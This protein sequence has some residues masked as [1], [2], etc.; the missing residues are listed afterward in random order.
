MNLAT[1]SQNELLQLC[2]FYRAT[3]E[4]ASIIDFEI[5]QGF[6]FYKQLL[7][8]KYR[9]IQMMRQNPHL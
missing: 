4:S 9:R 1:L 6:Q 8:E 5:R 3:F 7:A 2:S